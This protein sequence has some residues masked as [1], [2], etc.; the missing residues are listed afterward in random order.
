VD[1]GAAEICELCGH[2]FEEHSVDF[3]FALNNQIDD[4]HLLFMHS[5]SA[6]SRNHGNMTI[7]EETVADSKLNT[8]ANQQETI[9]VAAESPEKLIGNPYANAKRKMGSMALQNHNEKL[10]ARRDQTEQ[11]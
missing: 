1:P 5:Q 9:Q 3:N 10:A 7:I 4:L 11:H 2:T 6:F 8:F